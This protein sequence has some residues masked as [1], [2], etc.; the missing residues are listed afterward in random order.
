MTNQT[1]AENQKKLQKRLDTHKKYSAHDLDSW[2]TNI[3]D[4]KYGESLLDIGCGSGHLLKKFADQFNLS[5]FVGLDKSNESSKTI[6]HNKNITIITD[7][8]DDFKTYHR[9][10]MVMSNFALYYS[11][12]IPKLI[13]YIHAILKPNGRLFVSGPTA[14]NNNELLTIQSTISKT[15]FIKPTLIMPDQILPE[16]RKTFA[17]TKEFNFVNPITFPHLK[18]LMEYWKSYYIYEK[19]IERQF[20]SIM[21]KHFYA[22]GKFT[23]TKQVLGILAT[24]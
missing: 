5:L 15:D 8:M 21:Q 19:D 22:N 18:S 2:A 9:F 3:I 14:G 16:I 24:K 10:D 11:K 4:L 13:N 23:T 17:T 6:K 7:D 12:N 1:Y 20:A